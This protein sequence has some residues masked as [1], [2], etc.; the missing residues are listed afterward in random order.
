[1]EKFPMRRT[2]LYDTEKMKVHIWKGSLFKCK[3]VCKLYCQHLAYL[4][5]QLLEI[6][7]WVEDENKYEIN[8]VYQD[9]SSCAEM[10]RILLLP[11]ITLFVFESL[12][13]PPLILHFCSL[14]TNIIDT[15]HRYCSTLT[16]GL[17]PKRQD[18]KSAHFS[19]EVQGQSSSCPAMRCCREDSLGH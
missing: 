5:R 11:L 4:P 12:S 13:H 2:P 1:M 9:C 3:D 10:N 6:P 7:V 15:T 16:C 18:P 19:G 8:L 14:L 17:L